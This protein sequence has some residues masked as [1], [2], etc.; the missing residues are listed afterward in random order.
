MSTR[1]EARII[2]FGYG[3]GEAPDAH[4]TLNLRD[5]FRD[6][7]FSPELRYLTAEDPRVVD[8]VLNTRGIAELITYAVMAVH[9]FLSGPSGGPVTVAVGC[10]GGRHRGAAVAAEIT[11]QLADDGVSAILIH[12]D[13]N[14]PVIQRPEDR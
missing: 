9:A 1:T 2:S 8:A 4:L 11:R 3:H 5:H 13:M 14:R 6:P 7:Y 12:R 10:V